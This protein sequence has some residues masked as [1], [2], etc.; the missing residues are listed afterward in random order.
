M[1]RILPITAALSA[2]T[3]ALLLNACGGGISQDETGTTHPPG[4]MVQR[5]SDTT[6]PLA[7]INAIKLIVEKTTLNKDYNTTINVTAAYPDKSTKGITWII[8]PKDA[9]SIK[10][11]TLTALKDGSVTIQAKAGNILSNIVKLNIYWEV[12]GHRLPPEPDPK[13]NNATLLGVDVNHNGVRDDVERWIYKAYKHPIERAVFMQL[14]KALQHSMGHADEAWKYFQPIDDAASCASY[15]TT[16]M[17]YK[18]QNNAIRADK[19][20]SISNELSP[21]Q[22]NTETRRLDNENFKNALSGGV[23]EDNGLEP[24]ELIKK[25]DFN[26]TELM[27]D[28]Q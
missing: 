16:F 7:A 1:K 12:N 22:Y 4:P 8:T 27:K 28:H 20:T 6:T 25:C 18:N 3:L 15:W 26:A 10:G 2:I 21:I 11:D 17:K 9:V 23:I 19:T 13:I 5:G 14:A 24:E